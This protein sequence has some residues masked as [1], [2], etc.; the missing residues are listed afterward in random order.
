MGETD[1][2]QHDI[3]SA[4][5]SLLGATALTTTDWATAADRTHGRTARVYRRCATISQARHE[6]SQL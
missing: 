4:A 3:D 5:A 1:R 6:L 2:R